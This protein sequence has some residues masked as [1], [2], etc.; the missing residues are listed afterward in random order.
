VKNTT[1]KTGIEIKPMPAVKVLAT[2]Q[3]PS[4]CH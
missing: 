4:N 1:K 3:A 2:C